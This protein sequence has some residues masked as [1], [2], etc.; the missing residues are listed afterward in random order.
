MRNNPLLDQTRESQQDADTANRGTIAKPPCSSQPSA[1]SERHDL[2]LADHEHFSN[3]KLAKVL[4]FGQLRFREVALSNRRRPRPAISNSV[5]AA[6]TKG[7]AIAHDQADDTDQRSRTNRWLPLLLR[8][9]SASS[10]E[11][12]GSRRT[13]I[14]VEGDDRV[15]RHDN[16]KA[17]A[18]AV[19]A[20]YAAV[21]ER[22]LH[23]SGRLH[24]HRDTP[25]GNIS[26]ARRSGRACAARKWRLFLR[27]RLKDAG[28][29]ALTR[30]LSHWGGIAFTA[31]L[32]N[33]SND[34]RNTWSPNPPR[35]SRSVAQQSRPR[36][37]VGENRFLPDPQKCER[38]IYT[39]GSP[40]PSLRWFVWWLPR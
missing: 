24:R 21:Q 13:P 2:R 31:P 14:S 12:S 28:T 39:Q 29:N 11:P 34:S 10:S 33:L 25:P 15:S 40:L 9:R 20:K 19:E 37:S 4:S 22:V 18:G 1:R 35:Q 30:V 27:G 3:R 17:A 7:Q 23:G 36:R 26:T 6:S 32:T 38:P 5:R 8:P 16:A